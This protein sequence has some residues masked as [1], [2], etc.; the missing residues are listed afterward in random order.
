LGSV[1]ASGRTGVSSVRWAS[2]Q[3]N[4]RR[5]QRDD[6][7]LPLV[8]HARNAA[9]DVELAERLL[10][11][12]RTRVQHDAVVRAR[13]DAIDRQALRDQPG[14]ALLDQRGGV[15]HRRAIDGER[16]AAAARVHQRDQHRRVAGVQRQRPAER[17]LDADALAGAE[18]APFLAGAGSCRVRR[19]RRGERD[20]DGSDGEQGTHLAAV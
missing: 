10:A 19:G 3:S 6:D 15:L 18:E 17:R 5:R 16:D 2:T 14:L 9:H 7:G 12:R 11:A 8:G 4:G 13:P 20:R 1:F